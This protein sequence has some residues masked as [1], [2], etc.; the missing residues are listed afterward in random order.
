[1]TEVKKRII[2]ICAAALACSVIAAQAAAYTLYSE[3]IAAVYRSPDYSEQ[4][5]DYNAQLVEALKTYTPNADKAAAEE[6]PEQEKPESGEATGEAQPEQQPEPTPKPDIVGIYTDRNALAQEYYTELRK[7]G[8]ELAGKLIDYDVALKKL[9][10]LITRYDTRSRSAQELSKKMMT[11]EADAKAAAQAQE[12]ADAVFLEIRTLLFDISVMKADIEA[13]TGETLTDSFDF[14]SVYL[15]TDALKLDLTKLP[16]RSVLTTL[17][18]P[19]GAARAEYE[20]PDASAQLNAAVQS[21]YALGAA[22]KD[23]ISAAADV[24]DGESERRLGKI[25]EEQ[26]TA[27]N[28]TMQDA[29]LAA[30]QAKAD[31]AKAL[32]ALDEGCGWGLTARYGTSGGEI[33]ELKSTLTKGNKGIGLWT[34]LQCADGARLYMLAVPQ[35]TYP[36]DEEDESQYTFVIEYCKTVVAKGKTGTACVIPELAYEDGENY[37]EVT[38][39][40]DGSAVGTYGIDIFSPYGGFIKQK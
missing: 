5:T 8:R 33:K 12:E 3:N 32:F 16:D 4:L 39:Y 2:P 37:A 28:E 29:F 18:V 7:S 13:I 30:A 21:Y 14:D 23:Y 34:V 15:I 36:K 26:L 40:K 27:L 6:P 38:F 35:G 1:M 31:Y 9:R 20:Q 11:G 22:L 10:V 24:K 17:Y 19:E 25:T